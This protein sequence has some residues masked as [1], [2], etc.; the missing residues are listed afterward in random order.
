[1]AQAW[2]REEM[3]TSQ[4]NLRKMVN[5]VRSPHRGPR[6]SHNDRRDQQRKT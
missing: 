6:T 2:Y 3:E 5:L 4:S 1:M